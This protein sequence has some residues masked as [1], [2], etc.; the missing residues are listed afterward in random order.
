MLFGFECWVL[1]QLFHSLLS[2]SSR[3]SLVFFTFCHKGGVIYISEFI[4]ISPNNLE[5]TDCASSSPAFLM[6]CSACKL[7]KQGEKYS[8]DI[9]LSQFG[10][11]LFFHVQ[12]DLSY[13]LSLDG[14]LY[15]LFSLLPFL[16]SKVC[17]TFDWML[18]VTCRKMIRTAIT[19]IFAR[20]R[21]TAFSVTALIWDIKSVKLSIYLG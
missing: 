9:L 4:D 3:G 13:P 11:S 15:F 10:T 5:S 6:M 2:L 8:L 7:N 20:N 16:L 19:T 14:E 21:H 1:G 12:F 17:L 18:N